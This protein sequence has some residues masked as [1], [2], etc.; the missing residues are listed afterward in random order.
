MARCLQVS[1]ASTNTPSVANP[2]APMRRAAS[3][4]SANAARVVAQRQ[5]KS[6]VTPPALHS[7]HRI[8][9]NNQE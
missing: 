5:A 7:G 9:R 8:A 2:P 4:I 6:A 3:S 1:A